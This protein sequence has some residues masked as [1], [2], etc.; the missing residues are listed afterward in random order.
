MLHLAPGGKLDLELSGF[1]SIPIIYFIYVYVRFLTIIFP[2]APEKLKL[3][4]AINVLIMKAVILYGGIAALLILT[5]LK[6]MLYAGA[7]AIA[8][9]IISCAFLIYW[10][11]SFVD[12][13]KQFDAHELDDVAPAAPVTT[14]NETQ[15][16]MT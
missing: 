1:L 9:G 15:I 16:P 11:S 6:P 2:K 8:Y 10:R 7:Y 3:I 12:W 13:H 14:E 5:D 4:G